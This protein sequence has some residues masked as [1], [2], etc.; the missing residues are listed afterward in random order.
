MIYEARIRAVLPGC[1]EPFSAAEVCA[2]LGVGNTG[3]DY[4]RVY[5]VLDQLALARELEKTIVPFCRAR[6]RAK[7]SRTVNFRA[8][9]AD[10][11]SQ[12]YAVQFLQQ[13]ALKWGGDRH[14]QAD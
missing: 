1:S 2:A 3:R 8:E 10:P 7:F 9:Q 4:G 13:L 6:P 14:A 11:L 12:A 5:R